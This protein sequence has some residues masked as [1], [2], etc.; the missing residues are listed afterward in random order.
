M[1]FWHSIAISAVCF[2]NL[3]RNAAAFSRKNSCTTALQSGYSSHL[4]N[5]TGCEKRSAAYKNQPFLC[6]F[7]P[8]SFPY[9]EQEMINLLYCIPDASK[10][11]K[12]L[13]FSSLL[14]ENVAVD[15]WVGFGVRPPLFCFLLLFSFITNPF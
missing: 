2:S 9:K 5:G 13:A 11:D 12:S 6:Q 4:W 14:K 8:I 1:I 3:Y 10:S 15:A 7:E